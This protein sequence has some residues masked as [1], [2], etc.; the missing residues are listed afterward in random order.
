M[1]FSKFFL[2]KVWGWQVIGG[3][4]DLKKYLIA[5]VPH[6][7]WQDFFLGI[8]VR[9]SRNAQVNYV[10]KKSLFDSPLGWWFKKLGGVPVDRSK[11]TNFVQQIIDIYNERDE[12]R[13]SLAPEGTRKKVAK[14]KTGFYYIAHGAQVPVVLVAFD[15]GKKEIRFSEPQFTTGD[16]A[17][18]MARF[19]AFFKGAVGKVP[20]Y[21]FEPQS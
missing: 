7:H 12:F 16:V 14:L 8:F 20:E 15:Y 9:N 3:F 19:E 5:V 21:S 1:G 6:T 2:E 17:A 10:A 13:L 4:P 18:D 11:S